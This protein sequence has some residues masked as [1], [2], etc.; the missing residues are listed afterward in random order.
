MTLRHLLVAM[1]RR[2]YVPLA[3][4][5][6]IAL[7]AVMMVKDGGIYT[8]KTVIAFLRPTGTSLSADNG[9]NYESII[10]FASAVVAETNSS[11]LPEGYSMEDAPY[12][13]AGVREGTLIDLA[14]TGNQW[15]SNVS[16]A[17]IEIEIVGRSLEQVA[18]QQ[19]ESVGKVLSAAESLQDG[20]AVPAKNRVSASVVPL[21]TQIQFITP[22]RRT[23]FTAFAALFGVAVITSAWGSVVVDG[24]L[25]KRRSHANRD[26]RTLSH[27]LDE[28]AKI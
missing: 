19:E 2:W 25:S 26:E 17:E 13:G 7:A 9:A 4:C 21:T 12:Y 5:A 15:A 24:A 16:K 28:G 23:Q 22:S 14:R 11:R 8:T 1:L 20:V 6:C 18:R 3:I 27:R 10:A